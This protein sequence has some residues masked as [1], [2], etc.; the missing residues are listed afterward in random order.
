MAC[1]SSA[2]APSVA[3][4]ATLA[5]SSANEN[6]PE[7]TPPLGEEERYFSDGSPWNQPAPAARAEDQSDL[8]S[9]AESKPGEGLYVNIE[10]FS[11]RAYEAAETE[12]PVDCRFTNTGNPIAAPIPE[13]AELDPTVDSPMSIL[14]RDAG[15]SWDFAGLRRDEA[16]AYSCWLGSEVN[17]RGDGVAPPG[18]ASGEHVGARWF[19]SHRSRACGFPLL[20]G[21]IRPHELERGEIDHALVLGYPG[22]RGRFYVEPAST[23]HSVFELITEDEGLPCGA[24]VVLDP[25]LDIDSL[26]VDR[27]GKTILRALQRYGAFVGDYAGGITL[28]AEANGPAFARYEAIGFDGASLHDHPELLEHLQLVEHGPYL[29]GDLNR[30]PADLVA[31]SEASRWRNLEPLPGSIRAQFEALPNEDIDAPGEFYYRSNERRHDV[32]AEALAGRGGVTMGVG[33]D[34]LY[35]FAALSGAT[36]LVA[37]D[38]DPRIRFVHEIYAK[39]IAESENPERLIARFA[40]RQ[41]R[42]T[43]ELLQSSSEQAQRLYRRLAGDL[44]TYLQRVQRRPASWLQAQH[45]AHVRSLILSGRFIARTGDLTANGTLREASVLLRSLGA[46]IGV[47]YPSNA[48]QF[49]P[50]REDF[51]RN[52]ANIPGGDRSLLLRTIRHPQLP[53]VRGDSWHY[54]LHDLSDFRERIETGAYLRINEVMEDLIASRANSQDGVSRFTAE[55]PHHRANRRRRRE[56]RERSRPSQR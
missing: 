5:P 40:P 2:P 33:S 16:G 32:I 34:Q 15:R 21:L 24:R 43:A 6:V 35:T 27:N 38:Y 4:Q 9:I 46:Q 14:D 56:Q 22:I 52:I 31:R 30:N 55:I 49:F 41:R 8:R 7:S 51:V 17:L 39:L 26:P 42:Q 29:D 54:V 19:E 25:Q 20:A 50:F 13:G 28:Y 45:Y 3:P 11:I 48:E 37:I 47:F 18:P 23:A 53:N 10:R 1:G 44:H 36:M 12:V